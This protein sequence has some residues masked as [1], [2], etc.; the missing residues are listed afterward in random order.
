MPLKA[1]VVLTVVAVVLV[2][3]VAVLSAVAAVL[4]A[5]GSGVS[6]AAALM[7]GG[8]AFGTTLTLLVLL[9]ATVAELLP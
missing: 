1:V 9:V 7:R 6:P 3:L 4:L 8:V 5:R 2:L